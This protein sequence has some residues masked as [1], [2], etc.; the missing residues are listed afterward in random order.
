[1]DNKG[2]TKNKEA[3]YEHLLCGCWG[4]WL[5]IIVQFF[6]WDGKLTLVIIHLFYHPHFDWLRAHGYQWG[7]NKILQSENPANFYPT[8]P[9]KLSEN[10]HKY[11]YLNKTTKRF[12]LTSS[13]CGNL[14]LIISYGIMIADGFVWLENQN[15]EVVTLRMTFATLRDKN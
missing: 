8:L 14:S 10:L 7:I 6:N 2:D 12:Y 11:P 5:G 13:I 4:S 15:I 9:L 3:Y 1:M